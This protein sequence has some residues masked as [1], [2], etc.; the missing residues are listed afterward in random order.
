MLEGEI[1]MQVVY[2]SSVQ[3]VRYS[4]SCL[5]VIDL[6]HCPLVFYPPQGAEN[7]I[8]VHTYPLPGLIINRTVTIHQWVD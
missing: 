1:D 4:K 2:L 8:Q 3:F 6:I 5:V 7:E